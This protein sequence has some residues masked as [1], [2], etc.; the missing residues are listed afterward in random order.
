MEDNSVW[1][2]GIVTLAVG[3]LIGYLLGR[4]GENSNKQQQLIDQLNESQRELTE[5]KD[6]VNNHFEQ[7]A[8]LVNNLTESYKAVHQHLAKGS[9]ALC[10]TEHTP[11]ELDKA[12]LQSRI[13][14]NPETEAK[15]EIPTVTDEVSS[16]ES[17]PAEP[18]VVEPP[19]DYA[20]KKADEEGTLSES[21]GLKKEPVEEEEDIPVLKDH[22]PGNALRDDEH[23]QSA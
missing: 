15:A 9:E 1:I 19:R 16:P 22:I 10:L 21:Y 17:A 20:P 23:K 18:E 6:Q 8:D 7:T 2:I 12:P 11:V 5:Y 13:Q 14:D 3:A 4:S